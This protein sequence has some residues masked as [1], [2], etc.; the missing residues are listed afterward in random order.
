MP[1]PV[2]S[3]D[4][5]FFRAGTERR[6]V[7]GITYGPLPEGY[8]DLA[9]CR[10]DLEIIRGLGCNSLR[11]YDIPP[12]PFLEACAE[13][14]LAVFLTPPWPS[15]TD[16]LE[17]RHT[18]REIRRLLV[19]TVADLQQRPAIAGYFIG[20]EIPA[21]LVR[22]MGPRRVLRFLEDCLDHMRQRDSARL[23]SYADYPSTEYLQPSS[24]DFAA[25]NVYL[26]DRIAF[27]AY[28]ERL[29]HLA[30]PLP[31]VVS[32]CGLDSLRH[33]P[34]QQ[35]ET[36]CW[37]IEESA[38]AGLA[39]VFLFSFTD[40]WRN[41]GSDVE[42]WA[43][44]IVDRDRLPKLA[45]ARLPAWW[46]KSY[47]VSRA[48][49]SPGPTI[50]VVVCSYNGHGRIPFCLQSLVEQTYPPHE[51][52]VIDDGSQPTLADKAA[53]FPS[54][55]FHRQPHAGLGAAR[56]AGVAASTG[57][58][59]AFT[60]DDCVPD[61]QWL[62]RI[63][64]SRETSSWDAAGGPNLPPPE[65][66]LVARTIQCAPGHPSHVMLDDRHAEHLAGCNLVVT[67]AAFDAVGGFRS[68]YRIA[69]DDVDFCW[70]LQDIGLTLVYVPDAFVWHKRRERIAAYLTQQAGYGKAESFL[71]D[72]H[73]GRF[74]GF[75][76]TFWRGRLYMDAAAASP[77][78]CPVIYYGVNGSAPY[79]FLYGSTPWSRCGP[80][81]AALSFPWALIAFS[82]FGA[83]LLFPPLGLAGLLMLGF[84]LAAAVLAASGCRASPR[85]GGKLSPLL[86]AFLVLGQSW[87]RGGAFFG[88]RLWRGGTWRP[89]VSTDAFPTDAT[90]PQRVLL[91]T[92]E[93]NEP[94]TEPTPAGP[95]SRADMNFQHGLWTLSSL[96]QVE[97][98][99]QR[100]LSL[101][102]LRLRSGPR[103]LWLAAAA[104]LLASSALL[105]LDGH[106]LLAALTAIFAALF[107]GCLLYENR[108]RHDILWAAVELAAAPLRASGS[109]SS[110]V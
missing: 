76:R 106:P 92:L 88:G 93:L 17:N 24:I 82:C 36:L 101:F 8:T 59:I 29:Q 89:F 10:S 72:D 42:D 19:K 51:I 52:I 39:G 25:C 78:P 34:E 95:W 38:Q 110:R 12:P 41:A 21:H 80:W 3:V 68:H 97:E 85:A 15:H 33:G 57:E 16:F 107:L 73:R 91:R 79:Q 2:L 40:A 4:G 20:N 37:H 58:L 47:P 83:A 103:P 86:L 70:R 1:K 64:R 74:D 6:P 5:K 50:S 69:G 75:G 105:A 46:E 109:P 71:F 90:H 23:Y 66:S 100:Q 81:S 22:W 94:E 63:V 43:F 28:L 27:R 55:H 77:P 54:V 45:A 99:H 56:N 60:D 62:E 44:G 53:V 49:P 108:T 96:A 67:R 9:R 98:R 84:T 11:L 18:A 87:I 104:A 48:S 32:E 65:T 30:D 61:R 14:D 35:A 26:E 102:R 13:L 31:L 7:R